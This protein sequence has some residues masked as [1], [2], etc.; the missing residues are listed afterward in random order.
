MDFAFAVLGLILAG[1]LL[2][3]SLVAG[4]FSVWW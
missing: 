1:V 3:A 4:I 2:V